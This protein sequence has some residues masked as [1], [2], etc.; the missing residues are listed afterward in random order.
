MDLT[1]INKTASRHSDDDIIIIVVHL[2]SLYVTIPFLI[3]HSCKAETFP[4]KILK[5]KAET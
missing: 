1:R 5:S 4:K 2:H 3:L